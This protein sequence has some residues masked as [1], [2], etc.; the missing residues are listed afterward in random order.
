MKKKLFIFLAI[1][2]AIMCLFAVSASAATPDTTKETFTLSDG[3][4]LPIWDTDG[5]GLIWYISTENTEDGYAN[6]DYV[7]N[8]QTDSSTKPYISHSYWNDSTKNQTSKIT[9]TTASGATHVSQGGSTIVLANMQGAKH[10]NGKVFNCYNATFKQC[11]KIE[12]IYFDPSTTTFAGWTCYKCYALTYINLEDT[13][14]VTLGGEANFAECTALATIV[15]PNTVQRIER[16]QFQNTAI[17]EFTIPESVTY[18]GDTNFNGCDYLKNVYGFEAMIKRFIETNGTTT[19]PDK[20]FMDCNALN[21]PF[22]NGVIPEGVTAIGI[23]AF[24]DCKNGSGWENL[25]LPNTLTDIGQNGFQGCLGIEKAVLGAIFSTFTSYDG[26]KNCSN[27]K[28]VYIPNTLTAIP[29]NVFNS[30]A[31]N[32]VFYFTGTAEELDDVITN[33]VSNNTAFLNAANQIKSASEFEALQTKS[34]RYI[35]Y[36]YSECKAFYNNEHSSG[37]VTTCIIEEDVKCNRCDIVVVKAGQFT[38]HNLLKTYSYPNGFAQNG[39]YTCECQNST[40]CT[41]LN[42]AEGDAES[43]L[44]PI[45]TPNGISLKVEGTAVSV[46]AGFLIDNEA[47]NAYNEYLTANSKEALNVGLFIANST[48]FGEATG[49]VN[50][51]GELQT[52]KG[53]QVSIENGYSVINS[54]VRNFKATEQNKTLALIYAIYVVDNGDVSYVSVDNSVGTETTVG[55]EKINAITIMH[56]DGVGDVYLPD[57]FKE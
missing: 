53:F 33:T 57:S 21:M 34:G 15:L 19:I 11:G 32:C 28:E 42:V 8:N 50:A 55:T 37:E 36:G 17:T 26:F 43:V 23:Y 5:N 22:T 1:V 16:W 18:F 6:Y 30:A 52:T 24:D 56:L 41:I 12:A 31:S 46:T 14:A 13:A 54:A 51:E 3:T 2:A 38:T 35:V 45:I 27:L 9:I 29:G 48:Q 39:V 25:I 44:D 49:F 4:V 10:S 40:T 20:T 7:H 47:L